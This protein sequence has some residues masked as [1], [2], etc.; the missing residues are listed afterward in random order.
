[1]VLHQQALSLVSLIRNCLALGLLKGSADD[2]PADISTEAFKR[3]MES[4]FRDNAAKP[5][6]SGTAVRDFLCLWQSM[7]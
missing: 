6:F 2:D 4:K 1:M 7:S 5:L 3:R